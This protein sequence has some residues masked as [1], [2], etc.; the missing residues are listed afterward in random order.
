MMSNKQHQLSAEL[1][2]YK[3][4]GRDLKQ[5]IKLKVKKLFPER[6]IDAPKSI[7]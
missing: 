1:L 7:P 5:P 2:A 6:M 3:G 4:L